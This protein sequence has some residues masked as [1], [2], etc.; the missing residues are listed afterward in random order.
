MEDLVEWFEKSLMSISLNIREV[1]KEEKF[2]RQVKEYVINNYDKK[3]SLSDISGQIYMSQ[4]Y[5][6]YSFKRQTGKN[7]VEYINEVKIE[8]AKEMLMDP[9][10]RIKDVYHKVGFSDYSYFSR[11]FKRVTGTSP[12]NYRYQKLMCEP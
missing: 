3:I 12:L 1:T 2:V 5:L 11:V 7:L 10:V 6:S 9:K 4:S 8:K